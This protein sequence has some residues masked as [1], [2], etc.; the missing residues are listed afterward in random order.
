MAS[1]DHDNQTLDYE[2]CTSSRHV[3]QWYE[4]PIPLLH[5]GSDIVLVVLVGCA[6][7]FHL[8]RGDS[9]KSLGAQLLLSFSMKK[10][11]QASAPFVS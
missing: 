4:Q 6:T 8:K 1:G 5:F 3:K 2:D 10:N 7:V 11:I 9:V